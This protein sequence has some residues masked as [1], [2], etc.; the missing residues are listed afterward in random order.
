MDYDL[1]SF[2][3][4]GSANTPAAP[5]VDTVTRTE[6]QRTEMTATEATRPSTTGTLDDLINR[7]E[8][9]F[10]ARTTRSQELGARG[11]QVAQLEVTPPVGPPRSPSPCG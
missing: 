8:A 5:R 11:A 1:L 4:G 9:A 7:E 3:R 6:D 2:D 10:L